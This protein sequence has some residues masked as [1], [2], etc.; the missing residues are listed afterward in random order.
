MKYFFNIITALVLVFSA[1]AQQAD[2]A[3][4]LLDEVSSK[5]KSYKNIAIDF[6]YNVNG[7]NHSGNLTL[8][9]DKYLATFMGITQLY[10]G[11]KVYTVNPEDEEVTVSKLST[12]N[13]G[14]IT[15]SKAL[16]FFNSGY[17]YSWD[18]TQKAAGKNLQYIKLK[19]TSSKSSTKEILLGIDTATKHIY[20]IIEVFKNGNKSII[21]VKT[22]KTNQTL[23]KNHFT[24]ASSKYPNYYI[25]KLD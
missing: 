24:F 14:A 10:D 16:T 7:Q 1:Q 25:N 22:F 15:P 20:T 4:K 9:G 21:T 6:S 17:T 12:S 3:K 8:E 19:P 2:K 5:I 11:D 18:I 13:T 23:S